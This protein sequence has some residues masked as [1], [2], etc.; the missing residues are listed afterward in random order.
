MALAIKSV[1]PS[2]ILLVICFS[3]FHFSNSSMLIGVGI[4][5]SLGLVLGISVQL[6]LDMGL[7]VDLGGTTGGRPNRSS[8]CSPDMFC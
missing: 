6:G 8:N 7:G 4:R 2:T 3:T 1:I 5:V